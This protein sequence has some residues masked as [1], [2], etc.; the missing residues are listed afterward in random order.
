MK[1]IHTLE[2][3][4]VKAVERSRKWHKDFGHLPEVKGRRRKT[5]LEWRA[6]YPN[7]YL[8]QQARSRAKELNIN[9]DLSAEDIIIPSECP[10]LKTPFK[11]G[12]PYAMSLDKVMPSLGYVKDNVQVLSLKANLMKQDASPEELRNFA[13]WVLN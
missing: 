10:A 9:F 2:S 5:L 11:Y 8:L 1:S 12:T 13:L 4:R 7:K 6:K 3:K